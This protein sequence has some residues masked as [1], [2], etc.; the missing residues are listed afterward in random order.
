[1]RPTIGAALCKE[2]IA[3]FIKASY[4]KYGFYNELEQLAKQYTKI[5]QNSE[6]IKSESEAMM[7]ALI[8]LK[9]GL[10]KKMRPF[11]YRTRTKIAEEIAASERKQKNE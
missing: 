1:M 9:A 5:K 11:D 10:S 7:E 8:K 2:V 6:K 4:K 3:N